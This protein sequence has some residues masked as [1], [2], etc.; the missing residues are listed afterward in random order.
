[1]EVIWKSAR[2]PRDRETN[3]HHV[4][5]PGIS[6]P[7]WQHYSNYPRRCFAEGHDDREN[8]MPHG[9]IFNRS[10][11]GPSEPN[12]YSKVQYSV[13]DGDKAS[14]DHNSGA[15]LTFHLRVGGEG[16]KENSNACQ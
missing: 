2:Q 1:M 13:Q 14:H 3:A 4:H 5:D 12:R 9:M 8:G 7:F 11:G 16:S 15:A 10:R 6:D